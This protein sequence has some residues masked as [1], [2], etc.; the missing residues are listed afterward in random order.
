MTEA[1]KKI[2]DE[3]EAAHFPIDSFLR[4]LEHS[5]EENPM[6]NAHDVASALKPLLER[7]EQRMFELLAELQE[8]WKKATVNT[9]E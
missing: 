7:A 2:R 3:V 1:F 8:E 5:G 9:Q 6:V 4:I